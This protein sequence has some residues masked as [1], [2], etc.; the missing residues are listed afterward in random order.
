MGFAERAA[1]SPRALPPPAA[2]FD[3]PDPPATHPGGATSKQVEWAIL[4]GDIGRS[5]R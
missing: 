5:R 1:A 2:V 3:P 4:V